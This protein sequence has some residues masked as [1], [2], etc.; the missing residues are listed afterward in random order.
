MS[1]HQ[2]SKDFCADYGA[3][4]I[5]HPDGTCTFHFM[6]IY[7]T[8]VGHN[9]LSQR[10]LKAVRVHPL[11]TRN[12]CTKLQGD[13]FNRHGGIE[14]LKSNRSSGDIECLYKI[15]W[16]HIPQVL[17]FFS[18]DQIGGLT[19]NATQEPRPRVNQKICCIKLN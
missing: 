16:Q 1:S 2:I 19:N 8:V 9:I 14:S 17:R 13:P 15:S 11:E 18:L 6:T 3:R 5:V 10:V 12:I 7:P 4:G